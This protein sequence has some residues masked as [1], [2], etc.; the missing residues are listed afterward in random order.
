MEA[1]RIEVILQ[2][3]I[4]AVREAGQEKPIAALGEAEADGDGIFRHGIGADVVGI[5]IDLAG[6]AREDA[7]QLRFCH[8]GEENGILQGMG[9][10]DEIGMDLAEPAGL[11]NI[12]GDDPGTDSAYCHRTPPNQ[13]KKWVRTARMSFSSRAR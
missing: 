2:E 6:E 12:V 10:F 11:G 1:L 9:M 7:L 8:H 5:V 4:G 3:T 13:Q